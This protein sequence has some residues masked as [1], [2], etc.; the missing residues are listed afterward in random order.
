MMK[1]TSE[2]V[3]DSSAALILSWKHA[4]NFYTLHILR[5][6]LQRSVSVMIGMN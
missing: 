5:N 2:C 1:H 4:C 6:V 3:Y